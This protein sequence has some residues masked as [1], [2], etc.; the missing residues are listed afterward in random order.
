MVADSDDHTVPRVCLEENVVGGLEEVAPHTQELVPAPL[1]VVP[2][3]CKGGR[4]VLW[5]RT[6]VVAE[7]RPLGLGVDE[8]PDVDHLDVS[9]VHS[10]QVPTID[11]RSIVVE[12]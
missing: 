5:M 11:G 7:A 4:D 12:E 8:A 3:H 10:A 2:C 1:L 6:D 9:H